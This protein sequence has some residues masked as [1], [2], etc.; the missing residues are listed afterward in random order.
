MIAKKNRR[1]KKNTLVPQSIY[2]EL[3]VLGPTF[4]R[5]NVIICSSASPTCACFVEGKPA[6]R[7]QAQA[8]ASTRTLIVRVVWCMSAE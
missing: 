8:G 4:K 1:R 3:V 7:G 2:N 5:K 6:V